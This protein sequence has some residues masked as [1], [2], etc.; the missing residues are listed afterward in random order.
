[1]YVTVAYFS[2][3]IVVELDDSEQTDKSKF[4]QGETYMNKRVKTTIIVV[5]LICIIAFVL[6]YTR[7]LTVFVK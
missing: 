5:V 6:V 4:E 2:A 7:P 3:A 1:M